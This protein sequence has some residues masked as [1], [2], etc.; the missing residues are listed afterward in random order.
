MKSIAPFAALI[1]A[2]IA[3][4]DVQTINLLSETSYSS[5]ERDFDEGSDMR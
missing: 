3:K 1:A 4:T 2:A 5:N